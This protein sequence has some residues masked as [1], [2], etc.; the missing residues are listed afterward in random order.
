[1]GQVVGGELDLMVLI[2]RAG[3]YPMGEDLM[4][5]LQ[6]EIFDVSKTVR[7]GTETIR[8]VRIIL[9]SFLTGS[10]AFLKSIHS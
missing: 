1:M 9:T 4:L 6:P 3:Y 7:V 10:W 5:H 8:F 2:G